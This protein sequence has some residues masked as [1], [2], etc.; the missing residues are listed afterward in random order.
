MTIGDNPSKPL[1]ISK[2]RA[3]LDGSKG[4]QYWKSLEEVAGSEEV[5][6]F[7]EDEFPNRA[8]DWLDP[9]SRRTAFKVMAASLALAGVSACTKQPKELIVPYVRQPEDFLPGK[10]LF[11]A[12]AMPMFGGAIGLLAESHLGRPTKIEGNPDHPG[13]LGATDHFAQASVL[14]LWD[15][16]RSQTVTRYGDISNWVNFVAA[17]SSARDVLAL[18]NGEGLRILTET[19]NSPTVADLFKTIKENLPAV[20]WHVWEP[21]ARNTVTRGAQLAFGRAVEPVYHFENADVIVSLD[22]DFFSHGPG[23]VRYARDWADQRR[24]RTN[25]THSPQPKQDRQ[26]GYQ[27]GPAA[28][29]RNQAATHS[30]EDKSPSPH[31]AQVQA[32]GK[33]LSEADQNRMYVFENAPSI[34]GGLADHRFIVKASQV[35]Q[36]AQ[37][38]AAALGVAGVQAAQTGTPADAAIAMVAK[39]LQA[40]KGRCLVIAGDFQ[41]PEVHAL[42]H[43]MNQALGNA[44]KTVA[45]IESLD[46]NPVDQ[47]ES[48][49]EL[50]GDMNGGKVDTLLILGGNPV[51]T[52]PADLDFAGAMKKVK[53]RMHLGAYD[54]ET[55]LLCHWH[56]PEAHYLETWNDARG[57]DGTVTIMQPLIDPLYDGKTVAEVLTIVAGKPDQSAHELV[58]GYWQGR[59]NDDADFTPFWQTS[60]HDGIVKGTASTPVDLSAKAPGSIPPPVQGFE[61]VFRPD[62]SV[63][64]G[65]FANNGWL[66]EMPKTITT[67]TWDNTV[68]VSPRTAEKLGVGNEDVVEI[69]ASGRSVKG[70]IW[71]VPGHADESATIQ[72]GYG[73]SRGGRLASGI[74]YNANAI[75]TSSALWVIGADLRK[76]GDSWRLASVQHT[77]TMEEREPIRIATLAEY[78]KNPMFVNESEPVVPQYLTL[79]PDYKYEGYK[80]GMSIDLDTCTGCGTCVIACQAENNIAV[81]GKIEVRKGRHM[82]WIRVDRY[83]HGNLD[84]PELYFQ[85]VPCMM[86]ENAPCELVCPVA[87]TV[88]SGEGL[89]QMVYNRCV[90]TRY[91]SNNC[92]YKVRRF[93]FLLYSDW[94]TQ[95][96]Y[97]V[98]NPDV[99]VRSRGVMEKCSYCVQRINSAKIEAEREERRVRDGEITPACAQACPTQAIV[100]GDINDPKSRVAQLKAQPRK[101]GL[102][103]ELS[104]RPRTSYLGRLTNPNS[105]IEKG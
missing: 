42:A 67:L 73:R 50:V 34:T 39:D 85:P 55:S 104:T 15:P 38:L 17:L 25:I 61:V 66:Q 59:H 70:A 96:L 44:G 4:P 23:H 53:L 76:T 88:H 40:H 49:K 99:T 62:S 19:V 79:Y 52:V 36:I 89:N 12:T 95:S 90:G 3:K 6:A 103:Q 56:V 2:I 20:K 24:I 81:V 98:R 43:T 18:K 10:P 37:S 101:Y 93:N 102:L 74:G 54:D 48:L 8:P 71:V 60:L 26:E 86:C 69:K 100:F 33:P 72:L 13:S 92:P 46:A 7:L 30:E 28:P 83:F 78:K 57:Y 1:D 75:R 94:Y 91:C 77:Q 47:V 14:D 22:S 9:V 84:D 45:Y 27:A 64:D 35:G 32:E 58:K 11:Y 21:A 65:R 31:P 97:G 51:Y 16:D 80:W 41:P 63:W 5:Q 87:A 82:H 105:E 68:W 29:L